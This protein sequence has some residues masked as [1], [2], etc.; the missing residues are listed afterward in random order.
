MSIAKNIVNMIKCRAGEHTLFRSFGL[1]GIVDDTARITR[2]MLQTEV[3][4]WF[5]SAIVE[6][7]DVAKATHEGYFEYKVNIRGGE[8]G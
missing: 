1:G 4:R 6:S 3:N 5:P 2:N 8:N 7:C